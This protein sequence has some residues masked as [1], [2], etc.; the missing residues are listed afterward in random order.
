MGDW[1]N[2]KK[3]KNK[4]KQNKKK[5]TEKEKENKWYYKKQHIMLYE[6]ESVSYKIGYYEA[7][8]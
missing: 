6:M 7:G 8:H 3:N 2:K 1:H 5:K 4:T